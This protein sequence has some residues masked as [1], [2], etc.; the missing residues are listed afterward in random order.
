MFSCAEPKFTADIPSAASE[1]RDQFYLKDVRPILESRCVSCHACYS[2]PCQLNLADMEGIRRGASKEILY[3]GTRLREIAPTRL[4]VDAHTLPEWGELGF[5]PVL[6][7]GQKSIFTQLIHA[8]RTNANPVRINSKESNQCPSD[9]EDVKDYIKRVPEGGMPYGFPALSDQ[10]TA[11]LDRWVA[12]G[13][14][15]L[16]ANGKRTLAEPTEEE[17]R[18]VS[19][20]ED[21]LNQTDPKSKLI[22][23]YLYEHL[24]SGVIEFSDVSP[25]FFKLI[26]SET[27]RPGQAR[28]VKAR[29]PYDKEKSFT[30]RFQKVT[31]T[32]THKNHFAYQL[33]QKKWRRFEELFYDNPWSIEAKDLPGY[34]EKAPNPF[35]TFKAIPEKSRYKFLI[36]DSLYFASAFIKGT[37]CEGNIA[38]NVIDEKF[39][40]FFVDP[41]SRLSETDRSVVAKYGQELSVPG[42]GSYLETFYPAYKK[43]QIDFIEKKKQELDKRFPNGV[44]LKDLW[45]GDNWN[46]NGVLTIFRHFDNSYVVQG[47]KG[48]VPKTIWVVDYSIF[49]RLYYLLAAGFDV[50]GN[51][52]HQAAT[53][54]YMDNLRVESE[55]LFLSF[56]P[57]KQR[58]E[59]RDYWY[60]GGLAKK[61]LEWLNPYSGVAHEPSLTYRG[62]DAKREFLDQVFQKRIPKAVSGELNFDNCCGG[63]GADLAQLNRFAKVQG[64]PIR[65]LPEFSILAVENKA[66]DPLELYSLIHHREHLNI[67]FMFDESDR[68]APVEDRLMVHRGVV[69]SFP[70]SIYWV[71]KSELKAFVD[72]ALNLTEKPGRAGLEWK[73]KYFLSRQSPEFWARMDRIQSQFNQEMRNH[74]GVIDLSK[75]ELAVPSTH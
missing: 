45:D 49:E 74:G 47:A 71:Q 53:R 28:P 16:S 36:D 48:E 38:V 17:G 2:S 57:A 25:N 60:R 67:S 8:R 14:P 52:G 55:D 15:Q 69:G 54:L 18:E 3:N 64:G 6:K 66:G 44:G 51:V 13:Y 12:E 39:F 7:D 23:R 43:D 5:Y 37:V 30:Y 31:S 19:R 33:N 75:Y 24:F 68:L 40:V 73:A 4:G 27:P 50:Y 59:L 70:N 32:L 62:R 58:E 21:R 65:Y 42:A 34:E 1:S 26:R 72:G 29:R 61:K 63:S 56:L 20:W 10:E 9:Q 22:A 11:V 46:A 35:V 41:E